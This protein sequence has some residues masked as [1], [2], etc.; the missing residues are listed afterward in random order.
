MPIYHKNLLNSGL[1]P[2]LY[3]HIL[4]KPTKVTSLPTLSDRSF[5]V[6]FLAYDAVSIIS[7]N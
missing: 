7:V 6:L 5:K 4:N 2:V 3:S 1:L